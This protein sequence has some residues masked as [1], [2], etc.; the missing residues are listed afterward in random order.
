MKTRNPRRPPP[1]RKPLA[2]GTAFGIRHFEVQE[3]AAAIWTRAR[4]LRAIRDGGYL[5]NGLCRTWEEYVAKFLPDLSQR[6][7]NRLIT[8]ARVY[9]DL[10][11]NLL[12]MDDGFAMPMPVRESQARPLLRLKSPRER[13]EAWHKACI[14]RGHGKV[15]SGRLV[16]KHV[17]ARLHVRQ[18]PYSTATRPRL[19]EQVIASDDPAFIALLDACRSGI[20]MN[21]IYS[22]KILEDRLGIPPG[23]EFLGFNHVSPI[24]NLL[25]SGQMAEDFVAEV[26]ARSGEKNPPASAAGEAK[27]EAGEIPCEIVVPFAP[28]VDDTRACG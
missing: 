24:P 23:R 7:A 18:R 11:N 21:I 14:E 20:V 8:A 16:A 28:P 4:A 22:G 5:P 27:A 13:A 26:V 6:K 9:D 10:E 19:K 25:E 1:Q 2:D 12:P 3:A 17:A 15:P